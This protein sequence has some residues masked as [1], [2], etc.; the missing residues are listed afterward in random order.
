[1]Q[2]QTKIKTAIRIMGV[3]VAVAVVAATAAVMVA[4]VAVADVVVDGIFPG[5]L[6]MGHHHIPT[7]NY[8]H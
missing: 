1:M 6:S 3:E 7:L 2:E 5:M 4:A 8:V